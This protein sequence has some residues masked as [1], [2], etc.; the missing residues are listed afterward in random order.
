MKKKLKEASTSTINTKKY[1]LRKHLI[2]KKIKEKEEDLHF[3]VYICK[4][5]TLKY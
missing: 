1:K 3:N 5:V 2:K 4:E